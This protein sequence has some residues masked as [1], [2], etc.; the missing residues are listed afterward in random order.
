MT[1]KRQ[2]IIRFSLGLML[3]LLMSPAVGYGREQAPDPRS[4]KTNELDIGICAPNAGPFSTRI[5]N[6]Y[7]PLPEEA[8]WV[9]KGV[10]DGVSVRLRITVL[11]KTEVVAGVRNRVI[12][13]R[14]W[15]DE[16][17]VEVSWNFFVQAPDGTV[18]YYGED[19]DIYENRQVVSHDGAWRAGVGANRPG[20]IMPA[21]PKVGM[22]YAQEFAPGIAE[23]RAV[24]VSIGKG[25][26]VPA[27]S[28]KNTLLIHETTPLEP[29]AMSVKRFAPR[30]GL[31]VDEPVEL[32]RFVRDGDD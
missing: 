5:T 2:S 30:V 32:V 10:E 20:I 14:H 18:C 11:E 13:E 16:E 1:M 7:F 21:N 15:E 29:G 17:L 19:V 12:E 28:Y 26:R 31:I 22:S 9:L 3:A 8:V 27:G 6:P 24:I 25:V 4:D 23:D